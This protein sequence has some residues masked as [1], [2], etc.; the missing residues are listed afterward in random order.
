MPKP[1][2]S[3][4]VYDLDVDAFEQA[5]DFNPLEQN[6]D[7]DVGKCPDCWG[8]HKHGDQSGKFAIHREKKVYNCWVCG[9]GSLLSL[10]M[11]M[12]EMEVDDATEWLRQFTGDTRS[13]AEFADFY[14]SLLDETERHSAAMPFFNERVLERF[15]DDA[16]WFRTRGISD[17][18]IERYK[19][20]YSDSAMKSAPIK[21]RGGSR[22]KIDD[23]YYGPTA[24]F[25]HFWE[26][27]LVGWQNRW[28][29]WNP[30]KSKTPKWLP[31]YTNT[32]D[33]PKA[34]TLFNYDNALESGDPIVV[35]E[36]VP[37]VLL[38]ATFD[39][40]AVAYFG[41]KIQEAQLRLLRRVQA[42]VILAPDNDGNGDS[43]LNMAT[44]YLQKY[45]EV[46]HLPKITRT[47]GADLGDLAKDEFRQAKETLWEALSHHL[48]QAKT[49]EIL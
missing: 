28:M 46:Q 18:I 33:F 31:K 2:Y 41:S 4:F 6:G 12:Y 30:K 40:P 10:V 21:E 14:M 1:R 19:L 23:D 27:K 17:E 34:N 44:D 48:S 22:V 15:S 20:G 37:T 35:C 47:K 7:N 32:N 43:L 24:V 26:G 39:V 5:I 9:G 8:L 36:S 38:L 42:G 16:S 13:D 3:E 29:D 49:P 45:I 25:P 11:E